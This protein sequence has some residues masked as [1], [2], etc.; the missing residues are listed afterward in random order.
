MRYRIAAVIVGGCTAL[1]ALSVAAQE[2][3]RLTVASGQPPRIMPSM[4]HV[5]D[6][7]IPEVNKRIKA[8][9][10]KFEIEWKEAYA[11]SLLKALQLIDGVKDG[12]TDIGYMPSG[13]YPDKLPLEQVTFAAPFL[14]SDVGVLS[15][16]MDRLHATMPE[17]PAQYDRM[18][19][20]RLAG[21]GVDSY[22]LL[23]TFPVRRVEDI[24]GKKLATAGAATIWLRGTGAIPVASNIMEYYNSTK[25]GV[26]DGFITVASSFSGMKLPEAA[27]YVTKVGWGAQYAVVMVINKDSYRKLPAPLQKILVEAAQV[28]GRASDSSQV[29]AGNANLQSLAQFKAQLHE[30]PR[31]EQVRWV[32]TMPNIAKEWAD[33]M[34]KQG[35]P[36]TKA[37][38]QLMS[39]A[40]AAGATPVRDWDKE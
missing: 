4:A 16:V 17:F 2:K 28:W 10:L 20:V 25:T 40:R 32:K 1:A 38:N 35:L 36:G 9:G 33:R 13:F 27:P 24:K 3:I 29:A 26:F 23:T 6:T 30:L 12:T 39:E 11:G 19:Q 21:T 14:T 7:F 22:E 18:N 8:A 34:D 5:P 31:A 37:L 15:R